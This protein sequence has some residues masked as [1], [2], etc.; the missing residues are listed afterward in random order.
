MSKYTG[1]W[2]D[3]KDAILASYEN[4]HETMEHVSSGIDRW[5]KS[6]GGTRGALPYVFNGGGGISK[7]EAQRQ[8]KLQKYYT[9]LLEN[10]AAA[11]RVILMGPGLAKLELLRTIT[12]KK[13][14][15]GKVASMSTVGRLT[16]HQIAAKVRDYFKLGDKGVR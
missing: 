1:I 4:A 14:L 2:I 5:A 6:T 11:D 3:H 8:H 16:N 13:S 15:Q 12:K 7:K 10:V 9:G